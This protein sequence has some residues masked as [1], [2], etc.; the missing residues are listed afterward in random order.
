M[1]DTRLADMM[2]IYARSG[3]LTLLAVAPAAV[4]VHQ[5][6]AAVA[7]L[8]IGQIAAVVATGGLLWGAGLVAMRHSLY[9]QARSFVASRRRT[10]PAA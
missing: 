6:G 1:T 10:V 9:L 2:P 7:L 8:G 5:R 4:L 3:L